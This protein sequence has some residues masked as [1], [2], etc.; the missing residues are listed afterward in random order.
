MPLGIEQ[1]LDGDAGA[2]DHR[3]ENRRSQQAQVCTHSHPQSFA[4]FFVY[5]VTPAQRSILYSASF[6]MPHGSEKTHKACHDRLPCLFS[7]IARW[8]GLA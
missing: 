6:F 1:K 3:Q 7:G 5:Q 2:D 4:Q 8:A